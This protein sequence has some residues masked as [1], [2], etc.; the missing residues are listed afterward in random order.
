MDI[1]DKAK[2]IFTTKRDQEE[3]DLDREYAT[4]MREIASL[5]A[6]SRAIHLKNLVKNNLEVSIR[7]LV[8]TREDRYIS[9]IASNLSLLDSFH[10]QENLDSLT[11][12]LEEKIYG[13]SN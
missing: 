6:D 2:E 1:F 5:M 7:K 8:E 9:D 4:R 10:A 11:K 3:L 13:S 12:I